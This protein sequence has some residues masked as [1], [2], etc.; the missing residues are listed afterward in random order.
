MEKVFTNQL[1]LWKRRDVSILNP[2]ERLKQASR[3]FHLGVLMLSSTV[4]EGDIEWTIRFSDWP[5]NGVD[6]MVGRAK[7]LRSSVAK[8][9][10]AQ[11]LMTNFLNHLEEPMNINFGKTCTVISCTVCDEFINETAYSEHIN[12]CYKQKIRTIKQNENAKINLINKE[13]ETR[14][15]KNTK[16]INILR[17]LNNELEDQLESKRQRITCLKNDLNDNLKQL[18]QLKL[19]SNKFEKSLEKQ[20]KFTLCCCICLEKANELN[21]DN[22]MSLFSCGHVSCNNCWNQLNSELSIRRV[23]PTCRQK[24]NGLPIKIYN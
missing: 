23:C 22:Y 19:K 4:I 1:Q 11:N 2:I 21:R 18:D 5:L 15:N 3:F 20:N 10:A 13:F 17:R 9:V 8:E 7:S 16:S 24:L 6:D 14:Q 12:T